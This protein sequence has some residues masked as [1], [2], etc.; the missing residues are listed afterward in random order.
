MRALARWLRERHAPWVVVDARAHRGSS[1]LAVLALWV[2]GWGVGLASAIAV[3]LDTPLDK[4]P[5]SNPHQWAWLVAGNLLPNAAIITLGLLA[6][7][8]AARRAALRPLRWRRIS[9]MRWCRLSVAPPAVVLGHRGWSVMSAH[10]LSAAAWS[11]AFLMGNAAILLVRALTG[12]NRAYPRA[13]NADAQAIL[14]EALSGA[15][16]G[17]AE[18]ILF[19]AVFVTLLRRGGWSWPWIVAISAI[20]RGSFHIYYG[21]PSVG[22]FLWG[23]LVPLGYAIT[24][25]VLLPVLLHSMWNVHATMIAH[26]VITPGWSEVSSAALFVGFAGFVRHR[27][28]VSSDT[29]RAGSTPGM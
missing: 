16:A 23:A 1:L 18:E 25:R 19:G 2:L 24:G 26:E 6:L 5:P 17:P 27:L 12:E 21:W 13:Q 29:T 9:L 15:M 10:L 3:L 4:V 7:P 8:T 14:R 22:H 11:A 20:L 28:S